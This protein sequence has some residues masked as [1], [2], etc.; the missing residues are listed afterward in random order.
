MGK[1]IFKKTQ[2]S[3]ENLKYLKVRTEYTVW[4]LTNIR[5]HNENLMCYLEPP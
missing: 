1:E 4:Y 3:N 2:D 5:I